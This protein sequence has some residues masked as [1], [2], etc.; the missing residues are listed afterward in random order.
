MRYEST[1]H[2]FQMSKSIHYNNMTHYMKKKENVIVCKR[3][4]VF[5]F[6]FF[7]LEFIFYREGL[8]YE[9]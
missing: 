1:K 4:T 5:F 6:F 2:A 3:N 8:Q 7:N 9:N